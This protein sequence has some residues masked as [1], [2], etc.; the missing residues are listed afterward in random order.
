RLN[1]PRCLG[2]SFGIMGSKFVTRFH[3]KFEVYV[4]KCMLK[5]MSRIKRAL[6]SH[7]G[8]DVRTD[9]SASDVFF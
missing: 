3:E 8:V 5:L 9:D 4:R 2:I 1:S 6:P 7:F